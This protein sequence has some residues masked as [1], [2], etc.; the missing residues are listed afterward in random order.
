MSSFDD[1]VT[2]QH[3][4]RYSTIFLITKCFYGKGAVD[5]IKKKKK[6]IIV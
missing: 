5:S 1:Y 3:T 2:L 4:I 6:E